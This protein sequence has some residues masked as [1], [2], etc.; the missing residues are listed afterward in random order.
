MLHRL[1][2]KSASRPGFVFGSLLVVA[3][4]AIVSSCRKTAGPKTPIS[5]T[6]SID[7]FWDVTHMS[8]SKVGHGHTKIESTS[9][10][11]KRVSWHVRHH[12]SLTVKRAGDVITQELIISSIESEDGILE[13]FV[14]EMKAG[15]TSQITKGKRVGNVLKLTTA[16]GTEEVPWDDDCGGL[17]ASELSLRKNPL[18]T[19][20][21]REL[22]SW[23]PIFN[24]VGHVQLVALGVKKTETLDG[25]KSLMLVEAET[26]IPGRAP[27][28]QIYWVDDSGAVVKSS[29]PALSQETFRVSK[30]I[31]LDKSDT[32]S[33]DLSVS[34]LVKVDRQIPNPHQT[35]RIVYSAKM[36]GAD[37][38]EL[39]RQTDSQTV[40]SIDADT[41]EIK[42][43]VPDL[44][45]VLDSDLSI[46]KP[47][48]DDLQPNSLIQSNDPAIVRIA[49]TIQSS[50]DVEVV[51][52]LERVVFEMIDE[53]NFSQ[54]FASAAETVVTKQG[55]CTEHSVLLAALCRAKNIPSRVAVGLVY[56]AGQRGFAYHMWTESWVSGRWAGFDATIGNGGIGAAHLKLGETNLKGA[57]AFGG[58]LPVFH[59]MGQLQLE[60]VEIE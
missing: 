60:V 20:E 15:S 4:L 13:E 12:G 28:K 50:N 42:V 17:F 55:D 23:L 41:A 9:I 59:A 29:F 37:P 10:N 45:S 47:T 1:F 30:Q 14:T 34:T 24:K 19:G 32:E 27:L 16:D 2:L 58:M 49:N 46:D 22:K 21:K 56:D 11:G 35:K 48:N 53:K 44:D 38:S 6:D 33:F 51:R 31:A 52:R 25:I 43:V 40:K 26:Q 8:G 7:E 18:N 39:F 54:A 5:T 3:C 57:S 36:R